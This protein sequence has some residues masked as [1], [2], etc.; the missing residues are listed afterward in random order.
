LPGSGHERVYPQTSQPGSDG[1][2]I[3]EQL[4]ISG[5]EVFVKTGSPDTG[6]L[7]ELAIKPSWAPGLFEICN[8][9]KSRFLN[10][11]QLFI[12]ETG[13]EL[14]KW[15]EWIEKGE[16]ELLSLSLHKMISHL[17]IFSGEATR[18]LATGLEERLRHRWDPTYKES[19]ET[20]RNLILNAQQE[21]KRLI[22]DLTV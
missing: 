2:T 21:A 7:D 14:D 18:N 13:K 3:R 6:F 10:Y 19:L 17:K 1:K 9:K 15:S 5:S 16:H 8:G 4:K 11:L 20:L 12:K 22:D